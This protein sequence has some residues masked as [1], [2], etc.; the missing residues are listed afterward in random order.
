VWA[1]Y[2]LSVCKRVNRQYKHNLSCT[3]HNRRCLYRRIQFI[4]ILPRVAEYLLEMPQSL[5]SL[6]IDTV[7]RYFTESCKIFTANAI[8]TDIDTDKYNMLAF[9]SAVHNY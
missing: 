5:M 6:Q 8:L 1:I 3:V 4:D 2:N 9:I 7:C